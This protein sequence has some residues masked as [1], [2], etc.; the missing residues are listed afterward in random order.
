MS[1]T[2]SAIARTRE[3]W[4]WVCLGL[5]GLTVLA[6]LPAQKIPFISDDYLHI[7]LAR[8]YGPVH[9]WPELLADPLY[10]CRASSNVLAYW[11]D[12]FF[13]LNPL[14]F[15]AASLSLHV[16]NVWLVF[17][18]G[19]WPVIGWRAAAFGAAF[20][21]IQ[22]APQEAV[23]WFAAVPELLQ[24]LFA[25]LAAHAWLLWL[26]GGKVRFY[27]ASLVFLVLALISKE[28][29]VAIVPILA[30]FGLAEGRS[31]RRLAAALAPHGFLALVYMV[32]IFA[33]APE[34]GHFHDAGTF[35]LS[36]PFWRTWLYSQWRLFWIWGL[37][38]GI[39]LAVWRPAG[40]RKFLLATGAWTALA[41][42]PYCFLTYMPFVPSRHTY[43]ASAGE[44]LIVGAAFACLQ[45]RWSRRRWAVAALGAV[46]VGHQYLY[47]WIWKQRQYVERAADTED[48]IAFAEKVSGPVHVHCFPVGMQAAEMA[49][50]LRLNKQMIRIDGVEN[51][52]GFR[53]RTDVYCL[54]TE[55]HLGR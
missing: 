39:A 44:A 37:V 22:I 34:H 31:A 24:M 32:L 25:L 12:G 35:S 9:G 1:S 49:L 54:R 19:W 6:Y 27:G 10:R 7:H 48:L 13:G 15:H 23:I 18:L 5:A 8:Q 55:E 45:E 2:K 17:A 3:R 28:S 11:I 43:F 41:L 53:G 4:L 42:L 36:A 20:F 33:A 16:V 51:P 40:M 29:A 38:A 46:I 30:V 21:G 47:L 52:G 14:A 50:K 26:R